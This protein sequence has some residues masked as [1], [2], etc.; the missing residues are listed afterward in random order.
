MCPIKG[1]NF[2]DEEVMGIMK[3]MMF[4]VIHGIPIEYHDFF[5]RT[6][7]NTTMSPFELN[8]YAPWIIKFIRT[9]SS[10][11]NEDDCTN[12]LSYLPPIEALKRRA[13]PSD[14]YD[15]GKD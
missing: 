11:A 8:L 6:L 15:K 1:Y 7:G 4:N 12:H 2:D 13:T 3:N 10:I 5:L 9:K 14:E